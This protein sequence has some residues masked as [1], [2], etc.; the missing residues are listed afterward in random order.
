MSIKTLHLTNCF[1]AESGGVATFYRELLNGVERLQRE[2]CLVVPASFESVQRHG[3]YGKVYCVAA[4]SS[5]LSPGYR[6]LTPRHYLFP[7]TP[8]RRILAAEKP[9][10]VE[11]CDKYT[12][13]YMAALLRRGW[14]IA[15]YRPAVVGLS[16]ERMDENV[17]HYLCG[18]PAMA[19]LCQFYM[20]H[21][22]FPMFDHHIAVSPHVAGELHEASRGHEVRRGVW[23][24]PMG[25]QCDL[26]HPGR[27]HPQKRRWLENLTGAPDRRVLLLYAGRLVPEKNLGLLLKVVH[28]LENESPGR[29]HLLIAGEGSR[30]ASFEQDC[31]ARIPGAVSFMGH[32]RD[33][34]TLADIYANCDVFLHPN[35]GEPF[36]IAP[37]EAMAS[38]LPLIAPKGSGLTSYAHAGN[39]WL[40]DAEPGAYVGA[41]RSVLGNPNEARA[42]ARAARATAERFDWRAVPADFFELYDEVHALVRGKRTEPLL[43]PAF[44]STRKHP[45][46]Y[47]AT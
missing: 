34:Q 47:E 29:Y 22:Y 4:G 37:L 15:R 35:P 11:C 43:A 25:A 26:F 23:V 33:R 10:L 36:G 18:R 19:P 21:L 7:N 1:H 32:V 9:D 6:L 30:R 14:F 45:V 46:G 31:A 28:W 42:R 20:K 12:M 5:R 38:G 3:R 16:C 44:F 39:A 40:V 27:R 13:N 24:R 17:T 2:I 8:L 41:I